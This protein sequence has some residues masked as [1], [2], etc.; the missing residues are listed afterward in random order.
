MSTR[1]SRLNVALDPELRRLIGD[2]AR[3]R[4]TSLSAV[5]AELIREAIECHEDLL[6][7]KLA[8]RRERASRRNVPHAE[9]W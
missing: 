3:R 1:H 5:A 8:T 9:A 7:T 2:L 6:L 4:E